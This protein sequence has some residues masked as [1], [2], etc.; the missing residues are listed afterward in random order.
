MLREVFRKKGKLKMEFSIKR[1]TPAPPSPHPLLMDIISIHFYPT[2]KLR[3]KYLGKTW[4]STKNRGKH[5][6]SQNTANDAGCFQKCASISMVPCV[7]KHRY[8]ITLTNRP[9]PSQPQT[10]LTI[11]QA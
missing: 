9:S 11:V 2:M 6:T 3:W 10:N 8:P 1:R 4:K 5:R 7:Q